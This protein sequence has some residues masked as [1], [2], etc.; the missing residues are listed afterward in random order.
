LLLWSVTVL[1]V[2]AYGCFLGRYYFGRDGPGLALQLAAAAALATVGSWRAL[3]R[4]DR[5][6]PVVGRFEDAAG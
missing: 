2:L 4:K 3:R 6:R 1:G 5:S